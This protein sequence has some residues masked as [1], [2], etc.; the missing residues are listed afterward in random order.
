MKAVAAGVIKFPA[1]QLSNFAS[2]NCSAGGTAFTNA[3]L[4]AKSI[5]IHVGDVSAGVSGRSQELNVSCTLTPNSGSPTTLY[6]PAKVL[7]YKALGSISSVTP[8]SVAATNTAQDVELAGT[9]FVDSPLLKCIV[10]K[11]QGGTIVND[12]VPAVF[13]SATN[14]TCKGIPG[15]MKSEEF[16]I[17][18]DTCGT[19]SF[20]ATNKISFKYSK[21]MP[22]VSSSKFA[23]CTT[24]FVRFAKP[25]QPVETPGAPFQCNHFFNTTSN[26]TALGTDYKCDFAGPFGLKVSMRGNPTLTSGGKLLIN[27]RSLQAARSALTTYASDDELITIGAPPNAPNPNVGLMPRGDVEIG[28]CDNYQLLALS[29]VRGGLTYAWNVSL[30]SADPSKDAALATLRSRITNV[31]KPRLNVA[32][33]SGLVGVKLTFT[34]K[35]SDCFNNEATATASITKVN[36]N[37]PRLLVTTPKISAKAN[38]DTRIRTKVSLGCAAGAQLVYT[39]ETSPAVD[40]LTTN[41]RELLIPAG[42]LAAGTTYTATVT[43]AQLSD[44]SLYTTG[45]AQITVVSEALKGKVQGP[46]S[47]GSTGSIVL[48]TRSE[49]PDNSADTLSFQWNVFDSAG[50][51]VLHNGAPISLGT[52]ASATLQGN[53]L[54]AG[55]TYTVQVT[56]TKGQRTLAVSQTVNVVAGSP[57]EVITEPPL[58]AINPSQ[59]NVIRASIKS[60]SS[61]SF[62]WSAVDMGDDSDYGFID[63]TDSSNYFGA[64]SGSYG[65]KTKFAELILKPNI[66]EGGIK[67]K[68]QLTA[69]NADNV[70]SSATAEVSTNAPP[71]AGVLAISANSGVAMETEFT[72][73]VP[74][75]CVDDD[76]AEFTFGYSVGTT[77]VIFPTTTDSEFTTTLG[78]GTLNLFVKC[79]D[80]S[81]AFA[82]TQGVTVTTS[83]PTIDTAFVAAQTAKM[84]EQINSGNLEELA[85]FAKA[86]LATAASAGGTESSE[87][88]EFKSSATTNMV[89]EVPNDPQE[90]NNRASSL[91]T[92]TVGGADNFASDLVI[93]GSAFLK[94]MLDGSSSRRRRRRAVNHA[95]LNAMTPGDAESYLTTQGNLVSA[96]AY[97][98]S[99]MST[100]TSAI[101]V[102]DDVAAS[103]CK[104]YSQGEERAIA[105][106]DLA[107]VSVVQQ[108]FSAVNTTWLDLGC[109]AGDSSCPS[110]M[111]GEDQVQLG[112][113]L[114]DSYTSYTCTD[115]NGDSSATCAGA[116]VT[117]AIFQNDLRSTSQNTSLQSHVNRIQLY[118]PL[119]SATLAVTT[120]TT[121]LKLKIATTG[122]VTSGNQYLCV[123]WDSGSSS[124]VTTNIATDDGA[125]VLDSGVYYVT[126]SV[127]YLSDVVIMEVAEITTTTA[128]PTT[129]AAATTEAA[130]TQ[131]TSSDENVSQKISFKFTTACGSLFDD[132]NKTSV[133]ATMKT[134]VANRLNITES[135]MT[136]YALSCGSTVNEWTQTSTGLTGGMTVASL[137]NT[138]RT[139]VQAGTFTLTVNGVSLAPDTTSFSATAVTTASE[140]KSSNI[141]AIAGG[142]AGGGVVLLIIIIVVAMKCKKS[143]GTKV[144]AGGND[145][146]LDSRG[147]SA[148]GKGNPGYNDSP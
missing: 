105:E 106:S 70:V 41:K 116:C 88:T 16:E 72:Y 56:F 44:P 47:V 101:S 89:S 62:A 133:T 34:V 64:V 139:Q 6:A 146:E 148:H 124:W 131:G 75:G 1:G 128:A 39:W 67:Y 5:D 103:M 142:A 81:G 27:Y 84:T 80:P 107:V 74:E 61:G 122:N 33:E 15:S 12:A 110:W 136:G 18:L 83:A 69:T 113:A 111:V 25:V 49:D 137:V 8:S 90:K 63:L 120:L 144:G 2:V 93:S 119:T 42:V 17:S 66:M 37:L 138:L 86:F 87:V 4:S 22:A 126:C 54:E 50:D 40:G 31:T 36:K 14:I 108:D 28:D 97:D 100:K 95:S 13:N 135:S 48:K 7:F 125:G 26:Q 71:T 29:K 55:Q 129:T 92:S 123:R 10:R 68:F 32:G 91:S 134:A 141:A 24:F 98:S 11:K 112:Q 45:S 140:A 3:T 77:E 9:N 127:S 143:K 57:A 85:A 20:D 23:T 21:A 132:S 96:N 94:T 78:Q 43:V 104:S 79:T 60:A 65:S 59:K 121:P 30:A 109:T 130:T 102:V 118:N 115:A 52:G 53:K 145:L 35:V 117:S 73:S 99:S 58:G 38:R 19:K 147:G 46:A 82:Y 114:Q 51:G 76:G